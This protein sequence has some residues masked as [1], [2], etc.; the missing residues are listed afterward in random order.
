MVINQG[1]IFWI[2][3]G[4]PSGSEPGYMHPH[5]VVQNNLFNQSRI[6]TVVVCALTSNLKRAEAPGNVL[7]APGEANLPKQ[8]VV[9][10]SQIYTVD[11]RDL[12]EK[13]GTLSSKRVRE[14]LDGIQLLLEPRDVKE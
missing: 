1:D 2:D 6:N 8:S 7:L 9:N 10:V 4:A 14:I 11:K 3:L 5:V 13:I 12:V